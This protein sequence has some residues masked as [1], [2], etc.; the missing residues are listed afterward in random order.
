MLKN[1]GK[2]NNY[3]SGVDVTAWLRVHSQYILFLCV[4]AFVSIMNSHL[5]EQKIRKVAQLKSDVQELNWKYLSIKSD[6][7]NRS[8]LSNLENNLDEKALGKSGAKP[9]IIVVDK[10]KR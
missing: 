3:L 5:A 8:S 7:M 9:V 1:K 6:W 4:L 10:D 2:K